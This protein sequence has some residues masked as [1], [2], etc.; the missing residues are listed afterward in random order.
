MRVPHSF[1]QIRLLN[2]GNSGGQI[3]PQHR[4]QQTNTGDKDKTRSAKA[5][6]ELSTVLSVGAQIR[7]EYRNVADLARYVEEDVESSEKQTL[8]PCPECQTKAQHGQA[9]WALR[10]F[11]GTGSSEDLSRMSN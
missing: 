11:P 8:L 1:K 5:D 6:S 2:P 10:R 9:M 4:P 3:A 7:R